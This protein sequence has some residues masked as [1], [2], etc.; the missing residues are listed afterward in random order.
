MA[1][2]CLN[3]PLPT[4]T[5][6]VHSQDGSRWIC[7]HRLQNFFSFF[8]FYASETDVLGVD[9]EGRSGR[10]GSYCLLSELTAQF[11]SGGLRG[12]GNI[13]SRV[14]QDDETPPQPCSLHGKRTPL[15]KLSTRQYKQ[16]SLP[17][18]SSCQ[19]CPLSSTPV[20]VKRGLSLD[21][22]LTSCTHSSYQMLPCDM[23]CVFPPLQWVS[24][25]CF[26]PL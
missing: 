16:D 14:S 17:L 2:M 6:S 22:H 13:L 11:E 4:L 15:R 1:P 19:A 3:M 18:D 26:L 8:F 9:V 21:Y 25:G 23:L 5:V 20:F 7:T 24:M 10:G 12:G